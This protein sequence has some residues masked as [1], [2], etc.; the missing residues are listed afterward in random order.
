[1]SLPFAGRALRLRHG[2]AGVPLAFRICAQPVHSRSSCHLLVINID[3]ASHVEE[4]TDR[5]F[6]T[7]LQLLHSAGFPGAHRKIGSK[8]RAPFAPFTHSLTAMQPNKSMPDLIS[9][10]SNFSQSAQNV[11]SVIDRL[12][13]LSEVPFASRTI[14]PPKCYG[15][16]LEVCSSPPHLSLQSWLRTATR[17]HRLP[18]S[19]RRI[20]KEKILCGFFIVCIFSLAIR[21]PF[22]ETGTRSRRPTLSAKS[23]SQIPKNTS[24]DTNNARNLTTFSFSHES[25]EDRAGWKRGPLNRGAASCGSNTDSD[26]ENRRFPQ[27]YIPSHLFSGN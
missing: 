12:D 4:Q 20:G 23:F 2:Q 10:S 26:S 3:S 22:A 24:N 15:P 6:G 13:N 1:M 7:H 16:A 25:V 18:K 21:V 8:S 17:L 27:G 9:K 11:G 5:R 19:C 14:L